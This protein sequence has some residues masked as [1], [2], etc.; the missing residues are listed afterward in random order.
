MK[1]QAN[2]CH[3]CCQNQTV[4]DERRSIKVQMSV[5]VYAVELVISNRTAI[6]NDLL[7]YDGETAC[8]GKRVSGT[9]YQGKKV[10]ETGVKGRG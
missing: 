2:E 3:E 7:I 5:S 10:V 6:S 1:R 4:C 9:T 8:S